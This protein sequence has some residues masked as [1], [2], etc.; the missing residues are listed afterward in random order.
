MGYKRHQKSFLLK[1]ATKRVTFMILKSFFWHL[2]LTYWS[3]KMRL[4]AILQS[5][6]PQDS[7]VL[8]QRQK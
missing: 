7:M 3:L 8:A 4:Q 1:I 2:L 6:S 5:N